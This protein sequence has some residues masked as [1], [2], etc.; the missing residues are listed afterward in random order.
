[1]GYE[2]TCECE[3]KSSKMFKRIGEAEKEGQVVIEIGCLGA[4]TEVL[5][6]S[7]LELERRLKPILRQIP[8]SDCADGEEVSCDCELARLIKDETRKVSRVNTV[9][10]VILAKLEI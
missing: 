6:K 8:E 10:D 7:I 1:M 3:Q 5:L 2:E 4:T 9:I